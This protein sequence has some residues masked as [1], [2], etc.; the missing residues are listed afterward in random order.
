MVPSLGKSQIEVFGKKNVY[1]NI[2][3]FLKGQKE[4]IEVFICVAS[5]FQVFVKNNCEVNADFEK[6]I[7]TCTEDF[8]QKMIV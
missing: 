5:L 2:E 1:K 3:S 8:G 4:E 6:L 7:P